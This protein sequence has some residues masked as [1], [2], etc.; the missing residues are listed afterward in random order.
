MNIDVF[1]AMR[2]AL[3]HILG[4]K[5]VGLAAIFPEMEQCNAVQLGKTGLFKLLVETRLGEIELKCPVL[6]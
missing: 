4:N 3:L 5:P 6:V 1:G 2:R